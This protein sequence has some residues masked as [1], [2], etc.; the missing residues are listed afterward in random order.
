[1][2]EE[3]ERIEQ[4]KQNLADTMKMLCSLFLILFFIFF[5]ST[6]MLREQA[7][8]HSFFK[9]IYVT[10]FALLFSL[11]LIN[12]ANCLPQT[13]GTFNTTEPFT[14]QLF[15]LLAISSFSLF[16]YASLLTLALVY[17]LQQKRDF[18]F[19]HN[20]PPLY[21]GLLGTFIAGILAYTAKI[22]PSSQ[23]LWPDYTP[24]SAYSPLIASAIATLFGYI[25]IT[26]LMTFFC[27]VVNH[28]T[29]HWRKRQLL[30]SI[31]FIFFGLALHGSAALND[32][33]TW[34]IMGSVLGVLLLS[35]Y[36]V[37]IRFDHSIIPLATAGFM[38]V[39][40]VQQ[41]LFSAYPG[42]FVA[43]VMNIIIIRR[44]AQWWWQR[45]QKQ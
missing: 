45:M 20:L 43:A 25:T 39:H 11:Q 10:I 44:V 28:A 35:A 21:F 3:W 5:G 23:P 34:L 13:I 8:D 6:F 17:T 27:L 41:G 16:M 1:V 22:V 19:I 24:L 29:D 36:H 2:P 42:A 4:N 30:F 15:R 7:S 37:I 26:L 32:I 14:N 9:K 12:V 33:P 31:F 40:I 38:M 18:K